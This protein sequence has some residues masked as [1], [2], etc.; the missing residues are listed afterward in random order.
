MR[1]IHHKHSLGTFSTL[2]LDSYGCLYTSKLETYKRTLIYFSRPTS[3]R[4]SKPASIIYLTLELYP[5]K[6]AILGALKA[7]YGLVHPLLTPSRLS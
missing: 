3:L 6:I 5:L 7:L 1:D 4:N 2:L